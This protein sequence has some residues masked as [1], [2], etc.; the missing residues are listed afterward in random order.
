MRCVTRSRI[1]LVIHMV[2]DLGKLLR[3]LYPH[4]PSHPDPPLLSL[5]ASATQHAQPTFLHI[6]SERARTASPHFHLAR[7]A[8]EAGCLGVAHG[9]L[10]LEVDKGPHYYPLFPMVYSKAIK[11]LLNYK[12]S[13]LSRGCQG[14]SWGCLVLG[15]PALLEGHR[16]SS[17]LS[18]Q[19]C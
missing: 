18:H 16:G 15:L 13:Y 1:F 4:L 2:P 3:T 5:M 7:K 6:H 11:Y 9:I 12:H 19:L 10:F 17:K 14:S 8:P